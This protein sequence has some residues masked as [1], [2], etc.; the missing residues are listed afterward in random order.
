ME[1]DVYCRLFV[2]WYVGFFFM[3]LPVSMDSVSSFISRQKDTFELIGKIFVPVNEDCAI[4]VL[5]WEQN[6]YIWAC[7]PDDTGWGCH[8][9][10]IVY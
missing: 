10:M 4:A 2:C 6:W 8:S 9:V 1:D 3:F 7:N 5:L